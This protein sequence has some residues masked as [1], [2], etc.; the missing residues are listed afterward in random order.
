MKGI[1]LVLAAQLLFAGVP[2][3]WAD[4]SGGSDVS[5]APEPTSGTTFVW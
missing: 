2:A 1:A 4:E 5:A 3:S